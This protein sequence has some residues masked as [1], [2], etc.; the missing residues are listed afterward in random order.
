MKREKVFKRVNV[1]LHAFKKDFDSNV[2][3]GHK[4]IPLIN[5]DTCKTIGFVLELHISSNYYYPESYINKWKSLIGADQW[6]IRV[7]RSRLYLRYY[8]HFKS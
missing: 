5:M 4:F 2:Y 8:I 1:F 3:R 7:H 6:C